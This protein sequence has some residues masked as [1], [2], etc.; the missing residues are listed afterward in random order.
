M[1]YLDLAFCMAMIPPFQWNGRPTERNK[2]EKARKTLFVIGLIL[3]A[4][5][6]V[7][8]LIYWILN[9]RKAS[10]T[11]D[12]VAG[13]SEMAGSLML[14][15][16][17]TCN[18][19]VITI[20]RPQFEEVLA[21]LE[22]IHPKSRD[23]HYRCQHY[24]RLATGIM[25]CE[26]IYYTIFVIYF[27]M[28]PLVGMLFEYLMDKENFSYRLQ[29]NIWFPWNIQDSVLVYSL[30]Y[31]SL[32]YTSCISVAFTMITQNIICIFTFQFKL[33]IDGLA[34]QLITLDSRHAEAHRKLRKLIEYHYEILKLGEKMNRT[35]NISFLVSLVFTTIAIC[36]TSVAVLH[37]DL[38][39]AFQFVNG[40]I[41]FISYN[42]II[43]YLGSEVTVALSDLSFKELKQLQVLT[44]D[45]QPTS[46][47][48]LRKQPS[49]LVLIYDFMRYPDLVCRVAQL[50][51]IEWNGRRL[52]VNRNLVKRFIFWFGAINLLYH[53]IGGIMY[54]YF[55]DSSAM[56]PIDYVAD[57]TENKQLSYRIQSNSWNPWKIEGS[58]P[59]FF[60]AIVCQAGSAQANMCVIIFTQY[61]IT[62]F[63]VQLQIQFDGLAKRIEAIDARDPTAKDRLNSVNQSFNFTFLIILFASISSL[64]FLG[65]SIIVMDL[66]TALKQT[67]GLLIF[68]LYNFSLS[69]DGTDLIFVSE[70]VLS[71]AFYNNWYE[72]DLAYRKMLL[73][74]MIRASK[75]YVWRTYK[76]AP[77]SIDT[78]VNTLKLSYQMFTCVRSLK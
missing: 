31:L 55:V 20:N 46:L 17:A 14:S 78:Y 5:L 36:M 52:R 6:N 51:R 15:T 29:L 43:C 38:G 19:L 26:G 18:A 62:F 9:G 22:E 56:D 58:L 44:V 30:T 50:P 2:N 42:F 77:V 60:A 65:F 37:L 12:Y 8:F 11:Q 40:L 24:C 71:A 48:R 47:T 70:K 73:I 27:N 72:G 16:V 3:L 57:M 32:C 33:H 41:A 75:P 35:L 76:L 45:I 64:C 13:I 68:L 23:K 7:G 54:G 49:K 21:N 25:K 10:N 69:Q 61:L 63:V 66:G 74:L 4:Y 53:N 39:S 28:A 59:G 34:D 67:M 1:K